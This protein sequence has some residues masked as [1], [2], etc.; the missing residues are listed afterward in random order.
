VIVDRCMWKLRTM[1]SS[2]PHQLRDTFAAIATFSASLTGAS[3]VALDL[4][5]TGLT[6]SDFAQ[7]SYADNLQSRYL[8]LRNSA[9]NFAVTQLGV[10][11]FRRTECGGGFEA[12]P[13][14]FHCSPCIAPGEGGVELRSKFLKNSDRRF[15]CQ[16]ESL[17]FVA[18]HDFDFNVWIK[19]GCGYMSRQEE[20]TCRAGI[21]A[22]YSKK[23][24]DDKDENFS[25]EVR[26]YNELMST[27][28]PE[29]TRWVATDSVQSVLQRGGA[30]I[31]AI[32]TV[33]SEER[34]VLAGD[35]PCFVTKEYDAYRR[36][37]IHNEI[38]P[39]FPELL[40]EA[41]DDDNAADNP[42]R[43]GKCMR[44]VL[45]GPSPA[46]K[47]AK[48]ARVN[49]WMQ[50]QQR[51]VSS[52]V[53]VRR[54]VDAIASSG[55]P[56]V[57]HNC[58]LDLMQ[59][60]AKFIGDLPLS[61][62]EWCCRLNESFPAIFDTKHLLSGA[63]LRELVPDSTLDAAHAK[64]EDAAAAAATGTAAAAEDGQ[65]STKFRVFPTVTRAALGADGAASAAHEA[66][67]ANVLYRNCNPVSNTFNT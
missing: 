53:G 54:V 31:D 16:S 66:G 35:M 36:K 10:C 55:L 38:A 8:K 50:R 65:S 39:L 44:V 46:V 56:I 26:V 42:R 30:G 23:L 41:V 52:A 14:C 64:L 17:K 60:Y 59:V 6:T 47:T 18:Q 32:S 63:Q 24:N 20:A 3:F 43:R 62:G 5:L 15:M 49:S 25:Q 58:Y 61:L 28:F 37:I 45:L 67:N 21:A 48:L 12:L 13:F 33:F 22:E 40:F 11:V 4:E 2:L 19:Q 1:L 7:G 34:V 9:H 29:V 27:L 51:A 57:G